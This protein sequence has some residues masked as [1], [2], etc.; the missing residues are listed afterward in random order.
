MIELTPEDF[1]RTHGWRILVQ[2]EDL[3][4]VERKA[5]RK[6]DGPG[7]LYVMSYLMPKGRKL[8]KEL[9]E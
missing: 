9:S 5:K 4:Y 8:L 1:E 7:H 2:A 3:G 6:T